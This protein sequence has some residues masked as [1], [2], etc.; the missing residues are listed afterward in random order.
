MTCIG[1]V[2]VTRHQCVQRIRGG[3]EK[4][5]T[6]LTLGYWP[7]AYPLFDSLLCFEWMTIQAVVR[8]I[9]STT[10]IDRRQTP[11]YGCNCQFYESYCSWWKCT[12]ICAYKRAKL[13]DI[14]YVKRRSPAPQLASAFCLEFSDAAA[15]PRFDPNTSTVDDRSRPRKVGHQSSPGRGR[16][17]PNRPRRGHTIVIY[18]QDDDRCDCF[19]DEHIRLHGY[20]ADAELLR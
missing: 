11:C 2:T 7:S 9:H 14:R 10:L 5:L 19:I 6:H 1:T 3:W 18:E 8:V 16:A 12:C 4:A 20:S 13:Y 15:W 17:G